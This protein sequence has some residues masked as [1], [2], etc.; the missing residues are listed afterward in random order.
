MGIIYKLI[1]IISLFS[2]PFFYVPAALNREASEQLI[3]AEG[4]KEKVG[5]NLKEQIKRIADIAEK[6]KELEGDLDNKNREYIDLIEGRKNLDIDLEI[7]AKELED[8]A[9]KIEQTQKSAQTVLN[10]IVVGTLN[11]F[12]EESDLIVNQLLEQEVKKLL[13]ELAP[14]KVAIVEKKG[15]VEQLQSKIEEINRNCLD[16]ES[17]IR[18]MEDEKQNYASEYVGLVNSRDEIW[19]DIKN[20]KIQKQLA[21]TRPVGNLDQKLL[22]APVRNYTQLDYNK[23]GITY[24]T[25]GVVPLYSGGKGE[26]VYQGEL[27]TYGNLVIIDHGNDLRSVVLGDF[28]AKVKKG[29]VMDKGD[30]LGYTASKAA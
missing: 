20:N 3:K 16:I 28:I 14:L 26:V 6:I 22:E 15:Q 1:T 17:A 11:D 8:L 25:K 21:A 30:I 10:G 23:K 24:K 5:I 27:S 2:T 13:E 9:I 29:D 12:Q 19:S 4:E 7:A 18:G